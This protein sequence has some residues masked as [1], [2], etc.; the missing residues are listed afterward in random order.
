MAR[1][2]TASSAGKRGSVLGGL[3]Q[4]ILI[5]LI[6]LVLIVFFLEI[7]LRLFAPQIV[8]PLSG[9]FQSDPQAGY[10]LRSDASVHYRSSEADVTF[11]TGADPGMRV[12]P[13]VTPAGSKG[14]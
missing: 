8:P 11:H 3:L 2:V 7:G 10:R 14:A 5:I 4:A 1:T 13:P 6:T 9:L 12:V